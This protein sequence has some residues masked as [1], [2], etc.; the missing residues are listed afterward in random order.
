[1]GAFNIDMATA[2]W[3]SSLF[4]LVGVI[5]AI[6][7]SIVL[8]KLGPKKKMTSW[9]WRHHR[10]RSS[11]CSRTACPVLMASRIVEERGH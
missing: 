1:M 8:N 3:L 10:A 2:G 5:M 11:A 9:P 6:P 7:A 4:S